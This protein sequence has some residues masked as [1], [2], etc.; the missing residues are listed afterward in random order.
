MHLRV[1]AASSVIITVNHGIFYHTVSP[2]CMSVVTKHYECIIIHSA[3]CSQVCQLEHVTERK[4]K[5]I[6]NY[7]SSFIFYVNDLFF[8]SQN[9]NLGDFSGTSSE[10]CVLL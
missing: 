5:A 4:V 6:K 7:G 8:H 3:Q 10:I 1:Y 9:Q 2:D